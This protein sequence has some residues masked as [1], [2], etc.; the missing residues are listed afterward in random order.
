LIAEIFEKLSQIK[1]LRFGVWQLWISHVWAATVCFYRNAVDSE[2]P[3]TKPELF[4]FWHFFKYFSNQKY[5]E[6][7]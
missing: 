1:L 7:K 4:H 2:L 3:S 5:S 6:E